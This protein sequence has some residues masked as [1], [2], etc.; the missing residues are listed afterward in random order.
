[1]TST[2]SA[3]RWTIVSNLYHLL[4]RHLS[5]LLLKLVEYGRI[6]ERNCRVNLWLLLIKNAWALGWNYLV[7]LTH[8]SWLINRAAPIGPSSSLLLLTCLLSSLRLWRLRLSSTDW[9]FSRVT[10]CR[11]LGRGDSLFFSW[12]C[13]CW[14]FLFLGLARFTMW[15]F[16]FWSSG[17]VFSDS[18]RQFM[19]NFLLFHLEFLQLLVLCEVG[20]VLQD[21]L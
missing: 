18:M 19:H 12:R 14:W 6:T 17:V 7:A 16:T 15:L 8:W 21:L 4:L 3:T 13:F 20:P 10:G 1:M 2:A 5:R 9:R 11:L